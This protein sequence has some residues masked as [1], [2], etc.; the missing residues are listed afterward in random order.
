MGA[1]GGPMAMFWTTMTHNI[2]VIQRTSLFGLFDN[3]H[4]YAFWT[5]YDG[6]P[7]KLIA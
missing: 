3:N 5:K 1:P 7:S 6:I 2:G 4:K